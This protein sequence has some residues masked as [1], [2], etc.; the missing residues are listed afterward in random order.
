MSGAAEAGQE[1]I[2][3]IVRIGDIQRVAAIHVA[4]DTEVV[5]QAPIAAALADVKALALR[6]LERA[7]GRALEQAPETD[8][9]ADTKEPSQDDGD[10]TVDPLRATSDR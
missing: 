5:I 7:I 8:Q 3:E 6:K 2:F 4:S 9:D 1:V 10:Q